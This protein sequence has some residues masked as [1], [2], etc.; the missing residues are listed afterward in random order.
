MFYIWFR[1]H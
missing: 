1:C